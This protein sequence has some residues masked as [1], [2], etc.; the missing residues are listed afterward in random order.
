MACEA[1]VCEVTYRP[2]VI[3]CTR[4]PL[5]FFLGLP[6]GA[7]YFVRLSDKGE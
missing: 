3:L 2:Q 4:R 1:M 6:S 7:R 5:T